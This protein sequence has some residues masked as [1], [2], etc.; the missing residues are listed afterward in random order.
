MEIEMLN[1]LVFQ[2][3]FLFPNWKACGLFPLKDS[4]I[5]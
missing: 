5:V 4:I 2:K 3:V 1:Q